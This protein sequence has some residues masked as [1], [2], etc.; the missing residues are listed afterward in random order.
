M[1]QQS[2]N[3]GKQRRVDFGRYLKDL[4]KRR[5][6]T[7]EDVASDLGVSA[8]ELSLIERGRRRSITDQLVIRLA[9]RY[10]VPPE[11]LVM[12]KYWPQLPFPTGAFEP[13]EFLVELQKELSLKEVAEVRCYIAFL[14]LRRTTANKS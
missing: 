13:T 12:K 11:E 4:R 8:G 2:I 14:L 7:L 9:E 10:G 6:L 5:Q 1:T 3:F